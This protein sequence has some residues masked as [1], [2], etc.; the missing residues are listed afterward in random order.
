MALAVAG[1]SAL[2]SEIASLATR[3]AT[4]LALGLCGL[5]LNSARAEALPYYVAACLPENPTASDAFWQR[6]ETPSNFGL[7]YDCGNPT[8]GLSITHGGISQDGDWASWGF[9][10]PHGTTFDSVSATYFI[11]TDNGVG[12]FWWP[13]PYEAQSF[14]TVGQGSFL[15]WPRPGTTGISF[16]MRCY[17]PTCDRT[18]VPVLNVHHLFFVID[19]P[20]PPTLSA[21]GSLLSEGTKHGTETLEL[22]STDP[23]GGGVRSWKVFANGQV[24]NEIESCVPLAG[25]WPSWMGGSISA[26]P[27][28]QAQISAAIDTSPRPIR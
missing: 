2:R 4:V 10:A 12:G 5:L 3:L 9:N 6:S 17:R 7:Y 16:F 27:V 20:A 15:S 19:D 13:T 18:T 11:R 14:A 1:G 22:D 21:G 28:M 26:L 23:A 25:P 24:V 8:H